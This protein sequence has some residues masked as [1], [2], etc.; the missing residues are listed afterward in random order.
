[1]EFITPDWMPNA[2]QTMLPPG[3]SLIIEVDAASGSAGNV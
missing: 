1:M 3:K 2:R